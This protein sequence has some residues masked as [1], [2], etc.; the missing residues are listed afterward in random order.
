MSVRSLRDEETSLWLAVTRDV[1]R[2]QSK[3]TVQP[4]VPFDI[5]IRLPQ[6]HTLDL[7]GMTT[8]AAYAAVLDFIQASR[9]RYRFVTVV[10]GVSGSIRQEFPSWIDGMPDVR[11]EVLPGGGAVRLHFR[12]A[13][14]RGSV[15]IR[16]RS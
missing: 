9:Y 11:V 12:Q 2:L 1:A 5:A 3:S 13:T 15:P 16:R 14:A 10:T 6:S 7:H 4:A 8:A